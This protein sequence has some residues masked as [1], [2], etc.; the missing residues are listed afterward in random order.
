M[1]G[2]LFGYYIMAYKDHQNEYFSGQK[3]CLVRK[4]IVKYDTGVTEDMNKIY[5]INE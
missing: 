5:K 4:E 1:G 2:V 3:L